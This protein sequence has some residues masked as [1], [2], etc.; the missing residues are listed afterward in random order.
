MPETRYVKTPD[1][2]YIAYQVVGEG[3]VDVAVDFHS[4][5]SN[6]DLMWDEPIW[7]PFM[8]EVAQ[9]AR[10]VLHDRRGLGESSRNVPPA[11]LETRVADQLAVLDAIGSE[12]PI[13]AAA[14]PTGAM[15]ALL[16]AGHPDRV[17]GFVWNQPSARAA[18][19]SDYPWG[20]GPEQYERSMKHAEAYGTPEQLR[21]LVELLRA[22]LDEPARWDEE[23]WLRV[24][25]RILRNTS[26]PDVARD[27]ERIWWDTDVRAVLPAIQARVALMAG[28]RD[29]IEEARH[30]ASL[31]PD[32]SVTVVEGHAGQQVRPFIE[33]VHRLAGIEAP[34]PEVETVLT[35]VLFTDIVG[36]TE[37]Q[38]DLGDRG[39]RDLV[40]A[41]HAV[42]REALRRWRGLEADTAGDGFYATFDGPARAIRC[43]LEIVSGVRPL[44][45]E[46][47]A[48]VHTGEC[49]VADGKCT[50]LT[51]SIGARV[52]ASAGPGQVLVSQT[53]KDLVAGSG[54]RFT[55][56]GEQTL[57][58]VPGA[59]RLHVVG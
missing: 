56:L 29:R 1:G 57:K 21:E 17:S 12:R 33:A 44:G 43:A 2:V 40:Q 13:L 3:P 23:A 11:T 50:G 42:V 31:I 22:E 35:T 32:A 55:D 37:R 39:W 26:T 51:V 20:G 36:S 25:G 27:I 58:G 49:E 9:F 47:R 15:Y 8:Q 38:A 16:A 34:P 14:G 7:R 41:H 24:Y 59:W 52:A 4:W 48:G 18:W 46:V 28:T 6:V 45:I 10:L 19:A 30:L 54:L 53:V 5:A